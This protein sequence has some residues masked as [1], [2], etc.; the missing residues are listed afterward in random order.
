MNF[1]ELFNAAI[2]LAVPT[3]KEENNAVSLDQE[4]KDLRLDSLDVVLTF[5]YIADA[6]DLEEALTRKIPITT[7]GD[8]QNF[9]EEHGEFQFESVADMVEALK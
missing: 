2:K 5:S 1:V 8:I 7:L 4:I 9:C 3:H 6:Y